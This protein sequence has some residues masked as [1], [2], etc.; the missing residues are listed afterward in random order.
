MAT[1]HTK[2]VGKTDR[3]Y[4]TH[5]AKQFRW[6]IDHDEKSILVPENELDEAGRNLMVEHFRNRG[7]HIQSVIPGSIEYTRPYE[8]PVFKTAFKPDAVEVTESPKESQ[9]RIHD[10]FKIASS[11]CELKITHIERGKIHFEYTNRPGKP[12]LLTSEENLNR[13]LKMGYWIDLL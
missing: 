9:Y 8:K 10:K 1:K 6:P 12:P 11:E 3:D 7:W 5:A 2:L 13:A 4:F